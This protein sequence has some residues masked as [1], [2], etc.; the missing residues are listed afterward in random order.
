MQSLITASS[1]KLV[2]TLKS[3]HSRSHRPLQ[4]RF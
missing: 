2:T 3:P 4:Q 1:D